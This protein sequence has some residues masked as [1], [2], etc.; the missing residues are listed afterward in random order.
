MNCPHCDIKFNLFCSTDRRTKVKSLFRGCCGTYSQPCPE[1]SRLLR[2]PNLTADERDFLARS[3]NLD[4]YSNQ[5][6]AVLLQ[7]EAAI[8][9]RAKAVAA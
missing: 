5:Q 4:W 7:I 3:Q 9:T 8:A 6:V 1:P 2:S